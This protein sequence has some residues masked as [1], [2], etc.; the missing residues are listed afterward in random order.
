MCRAAR[1][2]ARVAAWKLGRAVMPSCA[3]CSGGGACE[4]PPPCASPSCLRWRLGLVAQGGATAHNRRLSC[5][6]CTRRP[7]YVT[8]S[9]ARALWCNS[10]LWYCA[11]HP[12]LKRHFDLNL[13]RVHGAPRVGEVRGRASGMRVASTLALALLA[14]A[15]AAA[16][17]IGDPTGC[18]QQA[19]DDWCDKRMPGAVARL[20]GHPSTFYCFAAMTAELGSECV[21]DR[22]GETARC[23]SHSP[24][25]WHELV[26][27]EFIAFRDRTLSHPCSVDATDPSPPP[28]MEGPSLIL[29]L[30]SAQS[31]R[32]SASEPLRVRTRGA[33]AREGLEGQ[34]AFRWSVSAEPA[35]AT[36]AHAPQHKWRR[37][38]HHR[39]RLQQ[40][41]QLPQPQPQRQAAVGL[42]PVFS[43]LALPDLDEPAVAPGGR[44]AQHLLLL[45]YSLRPGVRYSF[46]LEVRQAES[47]PGSVA[48]TPPRA[49]LSA[50]ILTVEVERPPSGGRVLSSPSNGTELLTRFSFSAPGWRD[51][52]L[53]LSF[54]FGY[55]PSLGGSGGGGSGSSIHSNTG[56]S[57]RSGGDYSAL[58]SLARQTEAATPLASSSAS[59]ITSA[60]L[61][62]GEWTVWLTVADALGSATH[63]ASEAPIAVRRGA[64][65]LSADRLRGVLAQV[66]KL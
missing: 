1:P 3:G 13:S 35:A 53:P 64:G 45:P 56:G 19:L 48:I 20:R 27:S 30:L 58:R 10:I 22:I 32:V 31:E 8:L 29:E 59:S 54:S 36:A 34:W 47:Q 14:G 4:Q 5:E 49:V 52:Q 2:C 46:S 26:D 37:R 60:V 61:P 25:H 16:D 33:D 38:R 50:A 6:T 63:S 41:Q 65:E 44:G 57:F 11:Y 23:L 43:E 28:R 15:A 9:A 40:Q 24:L 55:A 18:A 66:L 7:R 17:E 39:R 12:W 21:S 51:A 62:A 42:S